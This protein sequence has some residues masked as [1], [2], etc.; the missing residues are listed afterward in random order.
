MSYVIFGRKRCYKLGAKYGNKKGCR[1]KWFGIALRR[2]SPKLPT[3][4]RLQ[5]IKFSVRSWLT[6]MN[7]IIIR[8]RS[9]GFEISVTMYI[10][11]M[12]RISRFDTCCETSARI[13]FYFI[14]TKVETFPMKGSY[15]SWYIDSILFQKWYIDDKLTI[16]QPYIRVRMNRNCF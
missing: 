10:Q 13:N 15:I 11:F 14:E 16:F 5:H 6:W 2:E 8:T 4:L 7:T 12:R 3:S 1:R 9:I